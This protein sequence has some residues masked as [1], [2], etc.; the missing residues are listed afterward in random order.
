MSP[1][2]AVLAALAASCR[3]LANS[4][5]ADK[6]AVLEFHL[7]WLDLCRRDCMDE[8]EDLAI[9]MGEFVV[10]HEPHSN[11]ECAASISFTASTR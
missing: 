10:H 1:T 11:A 3:M 7:R 6:K 8:L 5:L 4:N 9:R 2:P